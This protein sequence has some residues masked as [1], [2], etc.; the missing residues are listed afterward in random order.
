M[1]HKRIV[2]PIIE[3]LDEKRS[4]YFGR[5]V[6]QIEHD[7][8]TEKYPNLPFLVLK[9]TIEALPTYLEP[10][11]IIEVLFNFIDT[12]LGALNKTLYSPEYITDP[13]AMTVQCSEFVLM[14]IKA[15]MAT[16]DLE[17]Q[18]FDGRSKYR[19]SWPIDPDDFPYAED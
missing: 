6:D 2:L 10:N 14:V 8:R 1:L 3:A 13:H 5:V 4:A 7:P 18:D 9:E 12:N 19:L 17:S 11:E 16:A 15:T